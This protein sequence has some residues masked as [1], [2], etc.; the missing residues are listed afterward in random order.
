MTFRRSA[1]IA[2]LLLAT[3]ITSPVAA[4]QAKSEAVAVSSPWAR[5]TP[6]GAKVGAAYL[7]LTAPKAAD[8]LLAAKSPVA[9]VVELHAHTSEGGIMKMRRIESIPV[10]AGK[11]VSLQPGGLH[12]M[13]MELK[14]PLK[15]GETIDLTLVF[16]KAGE[17]SIKVPVRKIGDPGPGGQAVGGHGKH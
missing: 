2:G 13:L 1:F 3:A 6:G 8:I 11:K 9:D 10:E 15:E 4:Q 16:E 5:A 12:I 17:V 14:Q 7:E